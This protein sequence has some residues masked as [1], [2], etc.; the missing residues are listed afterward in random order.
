MKARQLKCARVLNPT[1]VWALFLDVD[2]TILNFADSPN[3]VAPSDRV[4]RLL[5]EISV[6]LESAVALISG[7]AIDN[8]DHLFAPQ[9]LPVAGLHGL[10]RRDA[11]GRLHILGEAEALEHLRLPL[12]KLAACHDGTILEDKGRAL[13]IHYRRIPDAGDG[14]RKRVEELVRPSFDELKVIHG[15][16]VSEIK[17]RHAD[18]GSAIRAF[19]DEA[20][21]TGRLPVFIGDDVTDEDG[22]AA[23]NVLQGHAIH[24]GDGATTAAHYGLSSVNEVIEWLET[25]PSRIHRPAG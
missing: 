14:I 15:K 16:M 2:G 23:V 1:S 5:R 24:V 12:T 11:E 3:G 8:V 20:P 4:N 21:F 7:R 13:A 22:F 19:M 6:C 17:P 10:E 18:K 9:K 25:W